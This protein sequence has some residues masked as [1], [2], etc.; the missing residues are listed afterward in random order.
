VDLLEFFRKSRGALPMILYC[1]NIVFF[2]FP[3][4][5]IQMLLEEIKPA[6]TKVPYQSAFGS[7]LCLK[8]SQGGPIEIFFP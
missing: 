6:T 8:V 7:I 4:D 2:P 5:T 1:H 3:W